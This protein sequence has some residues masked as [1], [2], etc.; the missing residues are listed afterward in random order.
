MKTARQD[1]WTPEDDLVLADIILRHV[2]T[3]ST[4]LNAFH[5]AG[6]TL[7]RTDSACGFRWNAVVRKLFAAE[8]EVAKVA[9]RSHRK[10]QGQE[11]TPTYA[12]VARQEVSDHGEVS[13]SPSAVTWNDV[14]QFLRSRKGEEQNKAARVRH[15]EFS[16]QS[17]DVETQ[18]LVQENEQLR[19]EMRTLL[20]NLTQVRQDYLS[21]LNILERARK[22]VYLGEPVTE[23]A[24]TLQMDEG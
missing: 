17:K 14:I 20:Q 5:E 16:L 10:A 6:Q 21:L 22:E 7:G 3:G 24:S 19:G 1:A 13:S 23:E 4:Q 8:I 18:Q 11:V 2:R 9:R 12:V 15:L